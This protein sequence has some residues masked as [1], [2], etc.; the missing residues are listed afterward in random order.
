MKKT[1]SISTDRSLINDDN[2]KIVGTEWIVSL[3]SVIL[4][5]DGNRV[6]V[7]EYVVDEYTDD[8]AKM[9]RYRFPYEVDD[10][11]MLYAKFRFHFEKE[12]GSD[13]PVTSRWNRTM[14]LDVSNTGFTVSGV[15]I[16]T[17]EVSINSL[18]N[19]C[20][21]KNLEISV[22][23]MT[24]FAGDDDYKETKFFIRNTEGETIW[25]KTVAKNKVYVPSDILEAGKHY[26]IEAKHVSK[27]TAVSNTGVLSVLTAK[28]IKNLSIHYEDTLVDKQMFA[29]E[30]FS[31]EELAKPVV[32]VVAKRISDDLTYS[33]TFKN[34][35]K[36]NVNFLDFNEGDKI[37][38]TIVVN[39][40][41]VFKKRISFKKQVRP[42]LFKNK[43]LTPLKVVNAEACTTG[44]QN[45]FRIEETMYG[46]IILPLKNTNGF[47][48]NIIVDG[49]IK[50]DKTINGLV[51]NNDGVGV[52][53]IA[54]SNT[55]LLCLASVG[56]D[57]TDVK[58]FEKNVK[59]DT[60]VPLYT[61]KVEEFTMD[62][63]TSMTF[64]T[65]IGDTLFLRRDSKIV[66]MD[67][68]SKTIRT[69]YH[70]KTVGIY[71]EDTTVF[72]VKEDGSVYKYDLTDKRVVSMGKEVYPVHD[73][74]ITA[75][76]DKV[77][78]RQDNAVGDELGTDKIFVNRLLTNDGK[79]YLL[80]LN[81]STTTETSVVVIS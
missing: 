63:V 7:D 19:S 80:S 35:A 38:F 28:N 55:G 77:I 60:Y 42:R 78:V 59:S 32:T 39:D 79:E 46:E 13:E 29:I 26:T 10:N 25:F 41:E 65:M 2:L 16:N 62:N 17:P 49:E 70:E 56:K 6:N 9:F 37:R 12:E 8:P 4:D 22:S 52:V 36:C 27:T 51:Y 67:V 18:Q 50:E 81:D 58:V 71:S 30:I 5:T 75:K 15:I 45:F 53:Q 64:V 69:I 31:K 43:I 14:P 68:R 48:N 54:T 24:L 40:G 23:D 20:I 44:G 11:T 47:V 61:V 74:G 21:V 3:N 76:E 1:L 34:K 66:S 72:F 73:M 57:R 33:R